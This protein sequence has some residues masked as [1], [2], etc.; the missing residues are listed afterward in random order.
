MKLLF[1]ID[2]EYDIDTTMYMLGELDWK[3]RAETMELPLDLV[4]S[5][6]SASE[7]S[8]PQV[9]NKLRTEFLKTYT[10]LETY[11]IR[12]KDAYQASWNEIND[13]F[14]TLVAAKTHPWLYDEYI[15]VVTNYNLGVSNWDGNIVGRWWKENPDTQ[16]RI[17]AHEILLAHY[18][19]IHRK[20]YKTSN[21]TDNQIWAL[22]EIFAL[23]LTGLDEDFQKFWPWDAAGYYTE[24][25]YSQLVNLQSEL[26]LPFLERKSF[27]EYVRVGNE[28]VKEHF[29]ND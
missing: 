11:M 28:L 10:A 19:S 25:N 14:S 15:C 18:F 22:A 26:K 20:H 3:A 16:R 23:A 5:V 17:T 12:A 13:E 21:L 4:E 2:M 27:D 29:A 24:H 6:H 7:A 1:K 8:Y 9:A